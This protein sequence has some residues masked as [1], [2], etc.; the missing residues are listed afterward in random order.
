MVI[1]QAEVLAFRFLGGPKP[2]ALCLKA[3]I[4]L[5]QFTQGE[6]DPA[7]HLLREVVEE[8]ALV[9]AA[10]EATKQLMAAAFTSMADPGVV[11]GGDAG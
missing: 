9:L 11:A 5:G 7:Q 8:V 6:H 4:G 10:V 2:V 1:R 3:G